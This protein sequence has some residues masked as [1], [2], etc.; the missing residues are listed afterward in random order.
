MSKIFRKLIYPLFLAFILNIVAFLGMILIGKLDWYDAINI[1][2]FVNAT[3]LPVFYLPLIYI[4]YTYSKV[5]TNLRYDYETKSYSLY[6]SNKE[7]LR[8][9]L[10]EI[11]EVEYHVNRSNYNSQMTAFWWDEFYFLKVKLKGDVFFYI[12]CLENRNVIHYFPKKKLVLRVFPYI[13]M[14]NEAGPNLKN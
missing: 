9:E 13:N 12:T 8:F 3:Q 14:K 11:V 1:L 4:I 6:L 7:E 5:N 10:N 2:G